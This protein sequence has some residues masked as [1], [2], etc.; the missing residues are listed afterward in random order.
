MTTEQSLFLALLRDHA[1][2]RRSALPEGHVDWQRL[3][4]IAVPQCM[5]GVC[6]IQLRDAGLADEELSRFHEGFFSDVYHAVNRGLAMRELAAAFDREG[7]AFRPLKGLEVKDC[8]P[9][10]ELRGMTDVDLL[11]RPED[12]ARSDALM[13]ALGYARGQGTESVWVYSAKRC[14]FELHERLFEDAPG[15]ECAPAFFDRAW[16]FAADGRWPSFSWIF[17]LAH[18]AKHV[19]ESGIGF[20]AFLDLLFA[21]RG[22]DGALDWPW[23]TNTLEEIGLARFDAVC[24]ALCG[25]WFGESLPLAPAPLVAVFVEAV[26]D[27]MFADEGFGMENEENEAAAD[28]KILRRAAGPFWLTALHITA[29][30]V[31]PPYREMRLIP[32]YRF[33]DGRPWLLPAAWLYRWGYC[34]REKPEISEKRLTE[35]FRR[36]DRLEERNR[37]LRE[38]G[39]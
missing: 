33:V 39:L 20:R 6:Y 26:T 1:A 9:V 30:K 8:W 2:G 24:S 11:I 14:E 34:L 38:W 22:W 27:K 32:R 12:R 5:S 3:Y 16:S 10:P 18:L 13:R 35:T 15:G 21:A 17:L 7:L 37:R 36:R 25:A 28:A 23:I 31:F 4:E 19:R 29:R